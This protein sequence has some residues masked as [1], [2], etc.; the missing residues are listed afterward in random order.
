[1]YQLFVRAALHHLSMIHHQ[2]LVAVP[3]GGKSVGYND[4]CDAAVMD[5]AG[6]IIFRAGI[7]SARRLIQYDD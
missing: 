2:D 1:M 7:Q 4:A 6:Y 3:D 5:E